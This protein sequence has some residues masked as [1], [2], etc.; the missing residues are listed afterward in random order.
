MNGPLTRTENRPVS[1]PSKRVSYL[2]PPA[3]ILETNEGYVLEA[4]MPGV[5]KEGLEVVVENGE[6]VI[7]GHVQREE[8]QGRV[9]FRESRG[10]DFR[11]VFE[12]DPSINV[13]Q[14]SA[15]IEQGLLTMHLPKAESV[16]PRKIEVS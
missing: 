14:I 3:N 8:P 6:L 16:K 13:E 9:F 10:L 15:K 11:R 5:S 12:L 1:E 7:T 2:T 4:E